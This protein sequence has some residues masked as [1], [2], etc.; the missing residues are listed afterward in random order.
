MNWPEHCETVGYWDSSAG[1]SLYG[2]GIAQWLGRY[3]ILGL[4]V[5]RGVDSQS[6]QPG[7]E[8]WSKQ[9]PIVSVSFS[10]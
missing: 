5:S 10:V 4:R 1:R 3:K 8:S 9:A 7:L 2:S 6:R